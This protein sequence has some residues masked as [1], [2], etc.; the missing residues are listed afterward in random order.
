MPLGQQHCSPDR[1]I[2]NNMKPRTA[3]A[4]RNSI[5][6]HSLLQHVFLPRS[7][8]FLLDCLSSPWF[9]ILLLRVYP[10][11]SLSLSITVFNNVLVSSSLFPEWIPL[12]NAFERKQLYT[13]PPLKL[14][15]TFSSAVN[16]TTCI[17]KVSK[18]R[19]AGVKFMKNIL[20]SCMLTVTF[21]DSDHIWKLVVT[22]GTSTGF[23][24]SIGNLATLALGK[25]MAL[26]ALALIYLLGRPNWGRCG[27]G[28][29]QS[30][31][32]EK[33]KVSKPLNGT[34]LLCWA[35]GTGQCSCWVQPRG[36]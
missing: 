17:F 26:W 2:L 25:S 5:S 32:E 18:H 27:C 28:N 21:R 8:F 7:P 20:L 4:R 15:G 29:S 34:A 14:F 13:S 24:I 23:Q 33:G 35:W 16:H 30:H 22:F 3:T 6:P 11:P 31:P 12:E 10:F 36:Q 19:H 9:Y 1:L